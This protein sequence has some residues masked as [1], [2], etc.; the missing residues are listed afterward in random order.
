MTVAYFK[1]LGY[2]KAAAFRLFSSLLFGQVGDVQIKV[3]VWCVLKP[4]QFEEG[5]VLVIHRV[6]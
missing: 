1:E 6:G 3:L 5:T 4:T 2:E